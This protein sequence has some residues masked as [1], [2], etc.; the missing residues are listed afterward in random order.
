[1]IV[2]SDVKRNGSIFIFEIPV[3]KIK[4]KIFGFMPA[5]NIHPAGLKVVCKP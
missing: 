1:M 3:V 4:A 5:D 2:A